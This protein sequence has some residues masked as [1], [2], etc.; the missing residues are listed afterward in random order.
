MN[1]SLIIFSKDR[2]LQLKSLI[3][4]IKENTDLPEENIYIIY[5]NA[6]PEIS[7]N[8]LIES[9]PKCNFIEQGI[10]FEDIKNIVHNS[11]M[12]YFEFMV[13]DLIV[14]DYFSYQFIEEFFVNHPELDSFCLRMGKNIKCGKTPEFEIEEIESEFMV[15]SVGEGN[16]TKVLTWNTAKSLGKHWNY[17]WDVSDSIYKK[18]LLLDYI[19]KCRPEKESF[20]N[21]FE[22]HFY[23]CMPTTTPRPFPVNFIN[24]IRFCFRKKSMK[25]ACFEK[26]KCFTQGVNLVADIVDPKRIVDLFDPV[27]LHKKML[28]GYIIDFKSLKDV[29]SEQPNAGPQ[30]FKL[31]KQK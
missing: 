2:T 25:I 21:P 11:G 14:R 26:S 6:N 19:A 28:D 12:E 20:P 27:T 10:F 3:L 5:K 18:Q 7:Y 9:F 8:S 1:T 29:A 15:K 30:Y 31:L 22:D 24:A 23:T 13:D 16:S 4:S 17:G